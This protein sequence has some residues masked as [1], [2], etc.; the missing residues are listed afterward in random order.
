MKHI[1]SIMVVSSLV[2][3][4]V[5]V[6]AIFVNP[7]NKT[8]FN[9]GQELIQN[10]KLHPSVL[11][12]YMRQFG[13]KK[14]E[15]FSYLST[16]KLEQLKKN[17]ITPLYHLNSQKGMPTQFI[18]LQKGSSVWVDLSGNKVIDPENGYPMTSFTN[19]LHQQFLLHNTVGY[20]RTI[21]A[22]G[23]SSSVGSSFEGSLGQQPGIVTSPNNLLQ[24]SGIFEPSLIS[25]NQIPL[26]GGANGGSLF[27][28]TLGLQ[29][30]I[31]TNSNDLLPFSGL[32]A[33]SAGVGFGSG[34]I[35]SG[36]GGFEG[37]I[38]LIGATIGTGLA[39]GSGGG[40]A[41]PPPVPE[42]M[43]VVPFV[44]GLGWLYISNRKRINKT[45]HTN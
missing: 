34:G 19:V 41:G 43:T 24:S 30:G 40:A 16:L 7:K 2:L 36:L 44:I 38:G 29:P 14:N 15:V 4:S 33:P 25:T 42:F 31:V 13:M 6:G 35:F 12:S 23:S 37:G 20:T 39:V 17:V 45:A 9:T 21:G 8:V 28:N 18:E 3:A 27:E 10:T 32:Y 5:P 26:A 1:L 11:N 22:S